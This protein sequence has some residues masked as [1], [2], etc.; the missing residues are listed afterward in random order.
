MKLEPWYHAAVHAL[1]AIQDPER[2]SAALELLAPLISRLDAATISVLTG[3]GS[4]QVFRIQ[5]AG[6]DLVLR[7]CSS[8]LCGATLETRI[9][10]AASEAGSSPTVR[11]WDDRH[12]VVIMD[13]VQNKSL[14]TEFDTI[15]RRA[16]LARSS[17]K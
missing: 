8:A 13:H 12:G 10:V 3:G 16:L 4:A 11:A 5:H 2:R 6:G 15:E 17:R 9:Q 1:D 7:L 14:F